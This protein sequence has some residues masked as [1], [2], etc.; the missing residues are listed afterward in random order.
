[1]SQHRRQEPFTDI[2]ITPLTDIFLVLLIIMMVVAPM[3]DSKGLKMM[4]P[5][6]SSSKSV[7]QDPKVMVLQIT[8]S[9]GANFEDKPVDMET[10]QQVMFMV[11]EKYPDG[12]LIKAAPNAAHGQVVKAM[13]AARAA[14]ITKI[15][16]SSL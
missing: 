4:V 6:V 16:V 8:E 14:G 15:A 11:K 10:L 12:L 5:S 1:M 3:L 13:D 2:N 9:K 7:E